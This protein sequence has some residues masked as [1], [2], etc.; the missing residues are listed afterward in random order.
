M[1]RSKDLGRKR[2]VS[3]T[4]ASS[5]R[6]PSAGD[7]IAGPDASMGG[8]EHT[9]ELREER[10]RARKETRKAGEVVVR[11]ETVDEPGRLEVDA[12]REEVIVEHVPVGKVVSEKQDPWHEG[13]ALVVP[14]YEEELVVVKRLVMREQIRIRRAATTEKRVFEDTLRKER[15]R[16]ED[17]DET[18]AVRERYAVEQDVATAGDASERED[19]S[20]NPLDRLA[21]RILE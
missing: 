9:V 8:G 16:V 6:L 21:R 1:D 17:P 4:G 18:G 10:L 7:E 15:L 13:D 14:V 3:P 2:S 19:E 11:K 20:R 5:E 12:N